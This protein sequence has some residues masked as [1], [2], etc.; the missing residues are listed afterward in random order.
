MKEQ[1]LDVLHE[2][3]EFFA[4]LFIWAMMGLEWFLWGEG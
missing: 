2:V 3:V 1:I 4:G